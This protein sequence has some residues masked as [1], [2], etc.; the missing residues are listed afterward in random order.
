MVH[1]ALQRAFLHESQ[2]KVYLE[3]V[4]IIVQYRSAC[5]VVDAASLFFVVKSNCK[6]HCDQKFQK[7]ANSHP[8]T[9]KA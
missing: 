7:F 8:G 9:S 6:L 3:Q 5:I 4:L 2:L 1:R